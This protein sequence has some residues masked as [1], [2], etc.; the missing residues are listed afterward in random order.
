MKMETDP[1]AKEDIKTSNQIFVQAKVSLETCDS[2]NQTTNEN[3]PRY[4]M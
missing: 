4:K 1:Q 2:D 3:F